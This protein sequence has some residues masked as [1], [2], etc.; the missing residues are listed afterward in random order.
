MKR[1]NSTN[2]Q[3][4]GEVASS[5]L[6]FSLV[7]TPMTASRQISTFSTDIF[8][9]PSVPLKSIF[10]IEGLTLLSGESSAPKKLVR[11]N[12]SFHAENEGELSILKGKLIHVL[13]EID[14]GK[15]P[16]FYQI[17]F[18]LGWWMGETDIGDRGIFPAK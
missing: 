10:S 13:Q 12:Y 15:I 1:I 7:P 11:A 14:D 16:V 18:T 9:S 17:D 3:Y 6:P 5:P 8:S 4:D 2:P